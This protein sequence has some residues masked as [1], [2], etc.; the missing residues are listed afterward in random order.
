MAIIFST[1]GQRQLKC[2]RGKVRTKEK[3]LEGIDIYLYFCLVFTLPWTYIGAKEQEA[4]PDD[5]VP[6]IR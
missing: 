1:Y 3:R 5:G 2:G 4:V 6:P